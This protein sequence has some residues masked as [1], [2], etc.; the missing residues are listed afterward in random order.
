MK[1]RHP[2]IFVALALLALSACARVDFAPPPNI[3][4]AYY[5]CL[6]IKPQD[7]V[8]LYSVHYY[9][10]YASQML[11]DNQ[12]FV[13]KN[14]E[15]TPAMLKHVDEGY[16]WL[17][18]I[19][20]LLADSTFSRYRPGE[21]FDLVGINLGINRDQGVPFCLLFKDCFVMPAGALKLPAEGGVPVIPG[22]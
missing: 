12:V 16:A 21:K 6:E 2:G 4:V 13:F 20:C 15:V 1:Y 19:K 7:L 9:N 10:I 3:P 22:Y 11:Y 17:W 14:I 8:A 5:N 18:D